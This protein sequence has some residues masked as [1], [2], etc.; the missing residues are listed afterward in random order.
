MSN[1]S[2]PSW[3]ADL[4]RA[5]QLPNEAQR[6]APG[7]LFAA[8]VPEGATL[9]RLGADD[10]ETRY[11][12]GLPPIMPSGSPVFIDVA[13][14]ASYINKH[15]QEGR[16]EIYADITTH[17]VA[18]FLDWHLDGSSPGW[19]TH[20]ATLNFR[21]DPAWLKWDEIDGERLSQEAFV[22][23]LEDQREDIIRPTA[24]EVMEACANL[25][26]TTSCQFSSA[27]RL[28]DGTRQFRYS[29]DQ[30]TGS[31]TVPTSIT[32]KLSPFDLLPAYEV[33]ARIRTS[34]KDQK[35]TFKV[36]LDRPHLVIQDA[37]KH[38]CEEIADKTGLTVFYG[39]PSAP[40]YK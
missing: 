15:G 33:G 3:A 9:A 4:V 7:D 8:V 6:V 25:E 19:G 36:I 5:I 23:F 37:I 31:V 21:R 24:A 17:R 27:I 29:E 10:P 39:T 34:I 2:P 32:L 11:R 12:A 14:F 16:T 26:V 1:E 22:D 18:A 30:K 13:S 35:L 20:R 28:A 40:V 38:A